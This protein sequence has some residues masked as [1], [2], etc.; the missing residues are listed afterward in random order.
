MSVSNK[1]ENQFSI[2]VRNV[3]FTYNTIGRPSHR[4][5][6][7][8]NM[9]V[10][11][12]EFVSL[13]GPSG[14]GKTTLLKVLSG[15]YNQDSGSIFIK[16][17]SPSEAREYGRFS[18]IFQTPALLEWRTVENNILLPLE[19]HSKVCKKG[20]STLRELLKLIDLSNYSKRYPHELSG[21]MQQRVAIARALINNPSVLF[22]DEPFGA[23]DQITRGKLNLELQRIWLEIKPSVLFITHSIREACFLSD[24]IVVMSNSPAHIRN[25]IDVDFKRPRSFELFHDI[26]FISL[27]TKVWEELGNSSSI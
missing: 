27:E 13:I 2:D 20:N 11:E 25:I 6:E 23:L 5:L 26:D 21:G 1:T 10:Q 9:S 7:N 3:Y 14:C 18:V 24:K 19:L 8:I 16:G 17:L 15:L 22:M 12:N 4:A